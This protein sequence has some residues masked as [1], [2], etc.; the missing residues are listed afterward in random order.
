[1]HAC[2]GSTP[3]L[4][5][6]SSEKDLFNAW[7]QISITSAISFF[8]QEITLSEA[9]K[10]WGGNNHNHRK[11]KNIIAE[12][13][14]PFLPMKSPSFQLIIWVLFPTHVESNI[15]TCSV[16]I[17]WEEQKLGGLQYSDTTKKCNWSCWTL[18]RCWSAHKHSGR[19][20]CWI[21]FVQVTCTLWVV[22]L[23]FNIEYEIIRKS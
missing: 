19:F 7:T 14:F 12:E 3:C 15:T 9:M 22:P 4:T 6:C 10:C 1:M 18:H 2:W 17:Y 21:L 8:A 20:Y 5:C 11:M 13:L 16:H 23:G